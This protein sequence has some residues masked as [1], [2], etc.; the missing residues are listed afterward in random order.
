MRAQALLIAVTLALSTQSHAAPCPTIVQIHLPATSPA[1]AGR[2]LLFATPSPAKG[3]PPAQLDT[4]EFEPSATT[5]AAQE[6]PYLAPG[7]TAQIDTDPIAYPTGF[8]HLKPGAYLIQAVLDTRHDYAYAGR[9]AGDITSD[10]TPFTVTSDGAEIPTLTLTHT[11]PATD[12]W[13]QPAGVREA[14]RKAVA[15]S[16]GHPH[17]IDFPSATL[18]KFWGRPISMHAWVLPP[19]GYDANA[20]TTY[21]TV[22]YTHGFSGSSAGNLRP[23]S[24][25][26]AAMRDKSMP[27][28][29]WVFLDQSSPTGTVEFADSVNNGPWGEALTTELIPF[30]EKQYRMDAKPAGRFLTGHSSGGWATLWL[31]TTYPAFFGGTWSTS[32]DPSDFHAFFQ[33]VDLY[34]PN[35]NVYHLADGAAVPLARM[36]GKPMAFVEP[37]AKLEAVLGDSGGQLSSFDWVFSPRGADGK[38]IPLFNRE[39]GAVNPQVAAY[40]CAHY[41]I[42]HQVSANW[43]RLQPDL[44]GKIHIFVGTAD[45]FYLDGPAH[46]LQSVLDTRH[47]QAQF[48][49]VPNK[50]HFDLY[51]KPNDKFGLMKDMAWAMYHQARP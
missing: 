1:T 12:P 21:P 34:A 48:T 43:P 51:E 49:Y 11:I 27:P 17:F 2:L 44:T 23:L 3:A 4:N 30:L 32:P 26:D 5:T 41:D 19:P 18:T 40:W 13:D 38:P 10:V 9:A 47:A 28:M 46:R 35:A 31:Q 29:I 7:A 50:G 6:V 24:Y 39:T 42:A 15:A 8:S 37:V 33:G 36:N 22:Y 25:I 20:K 14:I 45:T 16:K